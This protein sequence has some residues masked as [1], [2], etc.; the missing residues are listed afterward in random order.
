M[1]YY[2]LGLVILK[3]MQKRSEITDKTMRVIAVLLL[4]AS[5]SLT[6][7]FVKHPVGS[8]ARTDLSAMK[9]RME[10]SEKVCILTRTK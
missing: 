3:R 10:G 6:A 7:A 2:D 5:L 9:K 1:Q 4:L 8:R